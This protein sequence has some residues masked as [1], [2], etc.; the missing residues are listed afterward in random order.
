LATASSRVETRPS[1]LLSCST[2]EAQEIRRHAKSQRRT[3]S[4]YVMNIVMRSVDS[5]DD[6][7]ARVNAARIFRPGGSNEAR[8]QNHGAPALL[9][10]R[11]QAGTP[12]SQTA[13][14]ND[15]RVYPAWSAALMASGAKAFGVQVA[16]SG[17]KNRMA[18]FGAR[19][20][21]DLSHFVR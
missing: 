3:V 19:H 13:R 5:D 15:Q 9:W 17:L 18:A 11:G 7:F 16:V 14:N 10:R 1:L 6:M 4:G 20:R 2:S 8:T 21:A 12:R